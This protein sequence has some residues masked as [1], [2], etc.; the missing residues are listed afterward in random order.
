MV[1]SVIS[2]FCVRVAGKGCATAA[3]PL[4][5]KTG[6]SAAGA[7]GMKLPVA[8]GNGPWERRFRLGM[9]FF[10]AMLPIYNASADRTNHPER[11]EKA[12][13]SRSDLRCIEIGLLR[14]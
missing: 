4:L 1:L 8:S 7:C 2:S 6:F 9:R 10:P 12:T 5:F 14:C 13:Y 11:T 3:L